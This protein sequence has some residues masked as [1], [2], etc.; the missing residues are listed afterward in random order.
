MSQVN[1]LLIISILLMISISTSL[2]QSNS[3][4]GKFSN[5]NQNIE[6]MNW[7]ALTNK[8]VVNTTRITTDT[9]K[10]L[11]ESSIFV[12]AL[13]NAT[14]STMD[15]L[16]I[17]YDGGTHKGITTRQLSGASRLYKKCVPSVVLLISINATS[18]GSG[19]IVNK[20]GE[21]VTNWHV[22]E[23]QEKMLVW[24]FQ[25]GITDIKD[26]DKDNYA[27]ADV[28]AFDQS[29]D[30]AMLRLS[31]DN[32]QD[33]AK[34]LS[35]VSFGRDYQLEVAQ[36]VFAIGRPEMLAW[37]F[38]YGVISQLRK[39][40]NWTYSAEIELEADVIQTQTPSNPGN[41]GGPLFDDR[42]KLIGINSFGSPGSDGLNFAISV[43]EVKSFV[44]EARA[45]KHEAVIVPSTPSTGVAE[46]SYPVDSNDNGIIDKVY[47]D[48]NGDGIYDL[49]LVDENED[50]EPDFIIGDLNNDEITDFMVYDKD[51]NGSFEYFIMDTD[52]DGVYDTAGVDTDGDLEPDVLFAYSEE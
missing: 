3:Q 18:L 26:L 19:I 32:K 14:N 37:S 49:M 2:A 48:L 46:N 17:G 9:E 10:A 50:N 8:S 7:T 24:F 51:G 35:P 45:G 20:S 52:Y 41:S 44:S 6:N 21:I 28:I 16:S 43:D 31:G 27:I 25:P 40:Y 13:V 5:Q 39:N 33:W 30:L 15:K 1:S 47:I 42:G 29:R 36:D 11:V 23:G 22:V 34:K 12:R 38:T 4:G